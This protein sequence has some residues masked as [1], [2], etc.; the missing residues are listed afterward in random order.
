MEF[1]IHFLMSTNFN[2]EQAEDVMGNLQKFVLCKTQ[3]YRDYNRFIGL[4]EEL[5]EHFI[6]L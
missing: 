2:I 1:A 3:I 4:S 5:N 6:S